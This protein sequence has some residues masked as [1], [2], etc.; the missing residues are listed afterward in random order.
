MLF[1]QIPQALS[2]SVGTNI[3]AVYVP[4]PQQWL[5][6]NHD[7]DNDVLPLEPPALSDDFFVQFEADHPWDLLIKRIAVAN[8]IQ[9]VAQQH[10]M[11]L[12]CAPGKTESVVYLGGRGRQETAN[13]LS[14]HVLPQ[15]T[16][17]IAVLPLEDGEQLRWC[18]QVFE[19]W[20]PWPQS[21]TTVGRM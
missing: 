4:M 16:G 20:T 7:T 17:C 19:I 2:I 3:F 15:A 13:H 18:R 6:P 14:E 21:L 10:A 9:S 5:F 11:K 8:F 12:Q 1:C